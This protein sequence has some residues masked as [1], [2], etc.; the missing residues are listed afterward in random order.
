M[1]RSVETNNMLFDM[2]VGKTLV[3]MFV[4]KKSRVYLIR[5]FPIEIVVQCNG[6]YLLYPQ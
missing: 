5:F 3:Y 4:N 1:N 2:F 6:K